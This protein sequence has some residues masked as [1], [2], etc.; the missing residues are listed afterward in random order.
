LTRL[1]GPL[2][3]V[4]IPALALVTSFAVGAVLLVLTD[5]DHLSKLGTDPAGAIGGAIDLVIRGYGA[6]LTGSIGD[7]GRMITALQTGAERDLARAIR[8][9]TEALLATTPVIFVALGVGIALHARMFN[10][11]AGGQFAMGAFGT[12]V[13]ADLLGRVLPPPAVL[14]GAIMIGALFGAAYGFVPGLLRARTG[15]HELITTLMLNSLVG[16]FQYLV[17]AG[18]S[19]LIAPPSGPP[20]APPS[21]PRIFDIETIRLDWGIV[22]AVAM[23]PVT[24]FLLFRTGLGFELR[25][26]GHSPTTARAAG[27]RPDRAMVLA[28]SLSGGIIGLGGAFSAL[29]P[30]AGQFGPD[31][32]IVA[33]ALALIA[34]LRPAGIVAVC[35]LYGALNNGA[36]GMVIETGT[37]LDLLVVLIA[38]ALMFVAAPGVIRSIWRLKPP[39][40]G[41]LAVDA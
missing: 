9:S 17:I 3:R 31:A 27:M 25:A 20:T 24:W 30:G 40:P 7:V 22:V 38:L 10:F 41:R 1:V 5:F 8:P 33:L 13:A 18:L 26:T 21:I 14:I 2:G 35:L 12:L 6:M 19:L 37:P 11:G 16:F 29:G 32:G 39:E 4:A 23:A 28:M 15:A 36:K 34:G